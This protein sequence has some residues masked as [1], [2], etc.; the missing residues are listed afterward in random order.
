MWVLSEV[1]VGKSFYSLLLFS[2]RGA[3]FPSLLC[4]IFHVHWL[5]LGSPTSPYLGASVSKKVFPSPLIP[6][7]QILG[8]GRDDAW[9]TEHCNLKWGSSFLDRLFLF[10][11]RTALCQSMPGQT[12]G[13]DSNWNVAAP[14]REQMN[15][16]ESKQTKKNK[17]K[18]KN[19]QQQTHE[20]LNVGFLQGMASWQVAGA[21]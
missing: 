16:T 11:H 20:R 14:L 7:N 19:N 2:S 13:P 8:A 3:L 12:P 4:L 15:K 21:I 9:V 17:T 6:C 5:C 18:T 10:N 1:I